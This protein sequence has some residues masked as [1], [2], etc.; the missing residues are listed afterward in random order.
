[1]HVRHATARVVARLRASRRAPAWEQGIRRRDGLCC[2]SPA[3]RGLPCLRAS[4]ACGPRSAQGRRAGSLTI[5]LGGP[6]RPSCERPPLLGG[7]ACRPRGVCGVRV[8]GEG[9]AWARGQWR[10]PAV[11]PG[12][13]APR[14]CQVC[15]PVTRGP[16]LCASARGVCLP[17]RDCRECAG[18]LPS[19]SPCRGWGQ[20]QPSAWASSPPRGT[21]SVPCATWME[22]FI[23]G[24]IR[25]AGGGG[26]NV[27][28]ALAG[29]ALRGA[30][31]A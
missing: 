13:L 7:A 15:A 30:D 4:A 19:L 5:P 22:L 26:E 14:A 28:Y 2:L 11:V 1:M 3:A 17:V 25:L 9:A 10:A 29:E 21:R 20:P 6:A 18:P 27:A 12:G 24:P 8:A 16:R 23:E 31:G